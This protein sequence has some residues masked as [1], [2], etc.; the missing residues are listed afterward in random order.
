MERRRKAV[1]ATGSTGKWRIPAATEKADHAQVEGSTAAPFP[2]DEPAT[3]RPQLFDLAKHRPRLRFRRRGG[4]RKHPEPDWAGIH[5]ELKT[6]KNLTLQLIWQERRES[7]PEG[8]GYSRFCDLYRQWLKLKRD[9]AMKVPPAV[10]SSDQE[11]I[12]ISKRC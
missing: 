9:V 5:H 3:D 11:L 6:H 4:W 12:L 8:Y 2:R 1:V 7:N 10:F